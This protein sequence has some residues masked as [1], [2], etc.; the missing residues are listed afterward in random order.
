MGSKYLKKIVDYSRAHCKSVF[1]PI[2]AAVREE[3]DKRFIYSVEN[4][5][6][7]LIKFQ[8][9]KNLPAFNVIVSG[10]NAH[11]ESEMFRCLSSSTL[12]KVCQDICKHILDTDLIVE[13]DKVYCHIQVR[14]DAIYG[15]EA[16]N[17]LIL[18]LYE[19][20]EDYYMVFNEAILPKLKNVPKIQII[21]HRDKLQSK[22]S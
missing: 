21:W 15:D 19:Q 5:K 14:L 22:A 13:D 4:R 6:W 16:Y 11:L 2:M 8:K 18:E 12:Q 10:F 17:R 3:A 7:G 9:S 20:F 1:E